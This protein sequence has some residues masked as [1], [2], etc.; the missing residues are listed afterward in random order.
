MIKFLSF[1]NELLIY[2]L[3]YEVYNEYKMYL[4][5][6]IMQLFPRQTVSVELR[7]AEVK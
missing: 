5:R 6:K 1:H 3:S 2:C 7:F 4:T